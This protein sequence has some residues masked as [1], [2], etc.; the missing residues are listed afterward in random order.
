MPDFP[1][2]GYEYYDY[3]H[4]VMNTTFRNYEDNA[5][6]KTGA[7]SHLLYTS[8]GASSNNAV[9]NVK[10]E[11]AKPVYYP[12]MERR[13]GNDNA[14]GSMAYKTAVFRDRD[15]SLGLGTGSFVV[16]HDGVNDSIA[17]DAQACEIKPD[18]NAA[19]CKG[20][21]GRMSFVNG[22][23]LGFGA[24]SAGGFG[25]S[26]AQPPVILSRNGKQIS[27]PVGTNVRSG[28]EFKATT[29]RATMDLHMIEMDAGSWVIVEIPGFTKAAS[30]T[31]VDSLD[32]LRK[33]SDTSFYRS[34]DAL[35]VK[36]VSPGDSGRGG[37]SG[38]V[39]VQVSR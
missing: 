34:G 8:F 3:R 11:N 9:E 24:I 21:V 31:P 12:P 15:G 13:W 35:W 17:V 20:D 18:W 33:A 29:E 10:F 27:I 32:A 28:I 30:G 22:R 26:D 1:I 2:R 6:R 23:G 4:D 36:L 39:S 38:G 16:I 7:I 19:L 5:T 37:H 14:A 25:G